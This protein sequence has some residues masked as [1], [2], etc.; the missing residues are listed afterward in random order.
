MDKKNI[1]YL[2][3]HWTNIAL[4]ILWPPV[5]AERLECLKTIVTL[6]RSWNRRNRFRKFLFL[7]KLQLNFLLFG[8]WHVRP[9]LLPV[10]VY[11]SS[12]TELCT[13]NV[14]LSFYRLIPADYLS[15]HVAFSV[16]NYFMIAHK[17]FFFVLEL[18]F[19]YYGN[20]S[21]NTV[22]ARLSR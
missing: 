12:L 22:L 3:I 2:R 8:E 14:S 18:Y 7:V 13:I 9:C 19:R 16:C 5:I 11:T 1:S 4:C 6:S 15:A 10:S 17:V 20:I 21:V